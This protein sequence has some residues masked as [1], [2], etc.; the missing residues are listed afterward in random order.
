MEQR[1][2][3]STVIAAINAERPL[4]ARHW[5]ANGYKISIASSVLIA[6]SIVVFF[7]LMPGWAP[8]D[9]WQPY[10]DFA[11]TWL[12]LTYI[13]VQ[14]GSLILVGSGTKNQ[15]WI[16]ALTSIVPLF[17]IFYVVLQ[18]HTGYVTLSSFQ[19]R[20]AW[21]TAYTMLLD[22]VVDLGVS[23]LLSRRVVD[24]GSGGVG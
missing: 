2:A 6:A 3:S 22:V 12:L 17:L 23:I 9:A 19:I 10:A 24:I 5:H 18:H 13:W 15:M 8:P 7:I 4:P 21:V 1:S 11:V 20:T 14:M 16:D